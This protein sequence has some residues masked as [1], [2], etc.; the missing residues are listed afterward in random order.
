MFRT[1][2]AG[3]VGFRGIAGLGT[4]VARL[5]AF[6]TR[7][8]GPFTVVGEIPGTVLATDVTRSGRLFAILSEVP[9]V[10]SVLCVSHMVSS[11]LTVIEVPDRLDPVLIQRIKVLRVVFTNRVI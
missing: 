6:P 9:G 4:A 3:L 2:T 5:T 1:G 8:G 11:F 10:S 7:F